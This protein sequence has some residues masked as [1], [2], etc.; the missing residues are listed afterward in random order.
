M[1]QTEKKQD[2]RERLL[3]AAQSLIAERGLSG[4]KAR[5]VADRA[6]SALGGLYTVFPDL[7]GLVLAVNLASFERLDAVMTKAVVG[8]DQADAKLLRLI[9]AYLGFARSEPHLWR[10]MFDH[11]LPEGQNIPPEHYDALMRLMQHIVAPLRELQ[12][13][14]HEAERM[15]RARTLFSAF[16]GIIAMSLDHRFTG[17]TSD[18]LESE[19]ADLLRQLVRGVSIKHLQ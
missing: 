9:E 6:G 17:V 7:N 19:L 16:H 13:E 11:R 8:A 3:R 1:K 18:A 4:L 15:I 14:K 10:A 5:D 2:L 12:P